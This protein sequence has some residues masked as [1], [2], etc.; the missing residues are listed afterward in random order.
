AARGATGPPVGWPAGDVVHAGEPLVYDDV[1]AG[2]V[3][4]V[5]D[6]GYRGYLGVPV[7]GADGAVGAVLSVYSRRPRRWGEEEREALRALAANA[8]GALSNAELYRR[9]ALERE[10]V[11]AILAN[12]AD[13]IVAVDRDDLVVVWNRAAEVITGVPA[14]EAI[15]RSPAQV[16]QRELETEDGAATGRV[17]IRRGDEEV[18]LL[19]SEAVMREQDGSVAGRIFAFRDISAEHAMETM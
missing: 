1:P 10:Q 17:A 9:V 16:L 2:V 8:G 6:R 12:I 19:L 11:L 4:P 5:V 18:W 7:P 14:A 13:G 3:D 15:G